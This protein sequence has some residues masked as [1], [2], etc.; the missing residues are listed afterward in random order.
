MNPILIPALGL[1][2]LVT[3]S[4]SFG[5]PSDPSLYPLSACIVSGEELAGQK[6]PAAIRHEGREIRFCCSDCVKDFEADPAAYI[7]TLDAVIVATQRANYPTEV[8]P[9]SGEELGSMG[10]PVEHLVG[11]RLVRLCCESCLDKIAANPATY[12]AKLDAAVVAQQSAD[13]PAQT[14][15]ISGGKLGGMGEPDNYVFAGRLVKF[16]C[17][18]CVD[19]FNADPATAI[20][21]IYGDSAAESVTPAAPAE[22]HSGHDHSGHDHA[23]HDHDSH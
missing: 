21:T 11:N 17:A 6:A 12:I 3:A 19:A 5:T 2:L 9:V 18:G 15:P 13:Y 20:A 10:D 1:A 14:C 8:C 7:S 23:G 22:D 4:A 16:C